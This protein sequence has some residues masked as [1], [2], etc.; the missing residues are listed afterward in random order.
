MGRMSHIAARRQE[1]IEER[2]RIA[3]LE[4]Y[5][6][7]HPWKHGWKDEIP[8][9]TRKTRKMLKDEQYQL[10]RPNIYKEVYV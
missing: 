4:E 8:V 1:Q 3:E 6:A 2:Q 9:Q 7:E 10:M 5:F